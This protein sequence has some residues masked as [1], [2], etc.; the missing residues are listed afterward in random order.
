MSIE[1]LDLTAEGSEGA[2]NAVEA[3][4]NEIIEAYNQHVH[5]AREMQFPTDTPDN[6]NVFGG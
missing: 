1:K 5:Y 4:I 2:L 3:K 6:P